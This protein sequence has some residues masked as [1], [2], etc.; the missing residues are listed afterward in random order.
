M[1]LANQPHMEVS[2]HFH[3]AIGNT[4]LPYPSAEFPDE[5]PTDIAPCLSPN[6]PHQI[7]I[8]IQAKKT[9]SHHLPYITIFPTP[10]FISDMNPSSW[11]NQPMKKL[12]AKIDAILKTSPDPLAVRN[13]T[14]QVVKNSQFVSINLDNLIKFSSL[15]RNRISNT[16][17]LTEAQRECIQFTP[18]RVFFQ[19][20]VNFCFWAK[21]G[22][23]KWQ[24]EYPEGQIKDGWFALTACFQRALD[25]HL[26]ILDCG[27]VESISLSDVKHFFRSS[28]NTEIP[29]LLQRMQ[30]LQ[31]SAKLLNQHFGGRIENLITQANSDAS[32]IAKKIITHFPSFYDVSVLGRKKVNFFKRAQ[33]SAYDLFLLPSL[34][35]NNIDQLTV[36]A[37]YKLP[38]IL[39]SFGVLI[40]KKSLAQKID[41]Y[42]EIEKG[43]QEETEIRASTIWA[44]ELMAKTSNLPPS[45][46]DNALW[47]LA[48]NKKRK[49]K[50]YHR[51]LTTF[52]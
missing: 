1:H 31:E 12:C 23:E 10:Q 32:T 47:Y 20:A 51:T 39:R 42:I 25:E 46:I 30:N 35:I 18:Q 48:H 22:K 41:S 19:D 2:G 52:Y 16:E 50:P 9:R 21:K 11:Y 17:L 3:T 34:Q 36:F 15:I 29:L 14:S 44:C 8:R 33:I 4:F 37:D 38:Q 13:T 49:M 24:V 26:P 5:S 6:H 7:S 43:S 45:V 27:Y 28:N 40:Y